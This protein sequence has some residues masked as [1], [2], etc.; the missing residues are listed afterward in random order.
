MY[1]AIIYTDKGTFQES[2]NQY[3]MESDIQSIGYD[4]E[5]VIGYE[6]HY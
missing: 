2:F 5:D 1:L 4:I 3:P 6:V